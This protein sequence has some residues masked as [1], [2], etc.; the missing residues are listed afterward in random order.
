MSGYAIR[1]LGAATWDAFVHLAEKHNGVWNGCWCTWFHPACAE[2]GERPEGNRAYK[3][4][5]VRG[6]KAHAALVFDGDVA[7]AWCEYGSPDEL[8]NIYHLKEY[9]AGL[10]KAPDYRL[11]CFFVDRNYRRKGV[12]AVAL[13]GALDLRAVQGKE[14]LRDG[15]DGLTQLGHSAAE[16]GRTLIGRSGRGAKPLPRRASSKVRSAIP[17]AAGEP[18]HD[19]SL[20][21]VIGTDLAIR[22]LDELLDLGH[23]LVDHLRPPGPGR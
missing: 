14:P 2:K 16:P 12:A 18:E 19:Q 13:G 15:Q 22:R 21:D 20:M 1:P 10:D 4:R 3:E 17:I 23:E 6:G 5:L 7:V 9:N 11:T 8:P